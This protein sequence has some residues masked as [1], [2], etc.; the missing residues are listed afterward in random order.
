MA[1][2]NN[3]L[4]EQSTIEQNTEPTTQEAQQ[5]DTSAPKFEIPTEALDFVGEGKKYKS[6][7]D[8]LRSV[9]HAQEH[10]KTLEEEMAQLK[11][12]LTRRKT[13]EE[14]LDEM[15]SGIQPTENTTQGAELD[16]DT[17]MNLVNQTL[18]QRDKQSKA[19][20]NASTVASKFTEQYGSQ[21]EEVYN[22]IAQEAGLT[23]EQ[24]NNL[25]AT[26]PNVVL[27]LSGLDAKSTPVGKPSS[28]INTQA[29]NN[30]KP[31][32]LSARVPKGASTKD[33]LA[34]WR[35]AGDKVKSQL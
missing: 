12:E 21:A 34:A 33:M 19:K 29:L 31:A 2:D 9:P 25:A 22:K 10:I 32:E 3:N 20:Q 24:L 23:V 4:Q 16:Q 17:I 28:S 26:S 1:E 35:A 15:K 6:A 13:A 11:E 27:K 18:E 7:E 14:L 30:T 8:A 5:A